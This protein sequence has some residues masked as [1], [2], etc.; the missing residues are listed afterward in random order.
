MTIH[1][2]KGLEFPVVFLPGFEEGI[3]PSQQCIYEPESIEEERR[4]AYV[5]LTRAK[6][7]IFIL[8]STSRMTF[9]STS[10][11]KPSRFLSEIPEEILEVSKSKDWKKLS[12]QNSLPHTTHDVRV[13]SVVFARNFSKAKLPRSGLVYSNLQDNSVVSTELQH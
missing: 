13:K 4:L 11:N 3:F 7:Q 6:E 10:H 8:N 12:V 2:S 5:A 1:A 9:G